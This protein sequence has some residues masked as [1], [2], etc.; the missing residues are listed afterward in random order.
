MW[1]FRDRI[2][3]PNEESLR[4]QILEEAHKSR[5]AIHRGEV[6]MYKD[7]KRVYWWPEMQKDVT[8]YVSTCMTCH[9]V[10]AEHKK[11]IRLLQL[12]PIPE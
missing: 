8:R 12:L 3:V 9:K 11:S 5:Y 6:K 2:C 1:Y 7:L 4:K 10:K